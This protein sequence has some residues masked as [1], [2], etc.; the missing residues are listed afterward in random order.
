[1]SCRIDLAKLA[2]PSYKLAQATVVFVLLMLQDIFLMVF[3]IVF[4]QQETPTTM[5]LYTRGGKGD[6]FV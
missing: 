2:L 6:I 4:V 5:S 3:N 1:V